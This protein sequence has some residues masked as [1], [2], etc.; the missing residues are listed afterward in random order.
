MSDLQI[1]PSLSIY[2]SF[3]KKGI[4]LIQED[5][6]E[7]EKK[8]LN[9]FQE[10]GIEEVEAVSHPP[11]YLTAGLGM[12]GDNVGGDG[13]VFLVG[14]DAGGDA[15]ENYQRMVGEDP[16]NPLFLRNY[17]QLLQV[18]I[19]AKEKPDASLPPA[20]DGL[21]RVHKRIVDGLEGDSSHVL[22]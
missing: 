10:L 2:T 3:E 7:E 9:E 20:V 17:A 21:L 12:Y 16:S 14:F 4:G 6:E 15:E 22:P 19:S 18:M 11:L 1:A 8:V 5:G 13:G